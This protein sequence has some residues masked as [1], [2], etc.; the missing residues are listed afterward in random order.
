M[1]AFDRPDYASPIYQERNPRRHSYG[2]DPEM[3][4]RMN[5]ASDFLEHQDAKVGA[6]CREW[7]WTVRDAHSVL[8]KM[9]DLR[10]VTQVDGLWKL[11]RRGVWVQHHRAVKGLSLWPHSGRRPIIEPRS[12]GQPK[13]PADW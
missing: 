4:A 6:F 7:G 12:G 3:E 2:R 11:T 13:L 8:F 1:H 5:K 10:E 9:A